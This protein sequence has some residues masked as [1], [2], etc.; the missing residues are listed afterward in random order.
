M[1]EGEGFC[2]IETLASLRLPDG[3]CSQ[4]KAIEQLNE[5]RKV[6]RQQAVWGDY[7]FQGE[8]QRRDQRCSYDPNDTL[9]PA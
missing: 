4:A 3:D 2:S 7:C 9:P 6:L 5:S 1:S 8:R